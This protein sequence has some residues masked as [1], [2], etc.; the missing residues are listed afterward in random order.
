MSLPRSFEFEKR[1]SCKSV[2]FWF[3]KKFQDPKIMKKLLPFFGFLSLFA[4]A[5]TVF[6]QFNKM[7]FFLA[8]LTTQTHKL[9]YF[10]PLGGQKSKKK[11][12]FVQLSK[13]SSSQNKKEITISSFWDLETS[14]SP[15][16]N[17]LTAIY[18]LKFKG[19]WQAHF[20]SHVLHIFQIIITFE[21]A[22]QVVL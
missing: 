20:F 7:L 12:C 17:Q 1:N 2:N 15:K 10:V 6:A 11:L 14:S 8:L 16:I 18:V 9:C 21:D 22:S 3:Q 13:T 19:A 5:W 4:L